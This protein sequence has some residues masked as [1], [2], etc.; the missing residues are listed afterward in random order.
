MVPPAVNK[1]TKANDVMLYIM[2]NEVCLRQMKFCYRKIMDKYKYV[3]LSEGRQTAV[4]PVGRCIASES[5]SLLKKFLM[6]YTS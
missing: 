1:T 2:M 5:N 6:V 4:E 3:I